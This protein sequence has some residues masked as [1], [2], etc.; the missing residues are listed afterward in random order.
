[1][2]GNETIITL[3]G[4][5]NNATGGFW[6]N[7]GTGSFIP[8]AFSTSTSYKPSATDKTLG[9]VKLT[10]TSTGNGSCTAISDTVIITIH[11]AI[12]I[13][14]GPDQ[15]ICADASGITLNG[16]SNTTTGFTWS[17]GNGSF[18]PDASTLNA[19]YNPSLTERTN[20]SVKLILTT[21][22]TTYCP[23]QKDTVLFTITPAPTVNAGTDIS[24]CG[25]SS[26]LN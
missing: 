11:P 18:S 16:S 24:I 7:S 1:M 6:T 25:D 23:P 20:G 12:I 9:K 8:D 3:N 4:I 10:L 19:T 2:C 17:N 14:A 21:S 26:L 22:A 15:T 5:V 13:S